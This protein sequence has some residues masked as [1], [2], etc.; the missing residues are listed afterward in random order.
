MNKD[1]SPLHPFEGGT[2]SKATAKIARFILSDIKDNYPEIQVISGNGIFD[3]NEAK[4]RFD[5]KADAISFG[6]IFITK[7]WRPEQIIRKLENGF[8][9]PT[10]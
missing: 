4:W 6:T 8:L 3:Y 7:P 10:A 2:S 9:I 5:L 1:K